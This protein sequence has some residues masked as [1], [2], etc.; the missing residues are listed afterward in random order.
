MVVVVFKAI[1]A[2][3]SNALDAA[4]G[5]VHKLK[6]NFDNVVDDEPIKK[7]FELFGSSF[8]I[9]LIAA[10]VTDEKVEA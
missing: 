4:E 1:T 3:F 2:V 5:E 6:S 7:Y 8:Q 10:K 9:K